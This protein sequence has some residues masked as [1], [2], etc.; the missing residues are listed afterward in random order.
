MTEWKGP[1][2]I[3]PLSVNEYSEDIK[4]FDLASQEFL[5]ITVG[6]NPA[7][8]DLNIEFSREITDNK[9]SSHGERCK[10]STSDESKNRQGK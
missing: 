9:S 3:K 6:P 4:G 7:S 5:N 8:N 10:W 1:N 2:V